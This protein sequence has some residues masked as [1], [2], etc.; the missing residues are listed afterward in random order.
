MRYRLHSEVGACTQA[1]R[2]RRF[3]NKHILSQHVEAGR[4]RISP[5]GNAGWRSSRASTSRIAFLLSVTAFWYTFRLNSTIG[6][7][8]FQVILLAHSNIVSTS[9][10]VVPFQCNSKMP[11]HRSMGLYLL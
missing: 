9:T 3:L 6:C 8:P 1:L 7:M 2:I 10:N 4:I 5:L 11:Q